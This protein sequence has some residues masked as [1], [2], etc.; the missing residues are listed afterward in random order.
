MGQGEKEGRPAVDGALGPDAAAVARD[1]ALG[2]READPVAGEFGR[3][4]QALERREQ[5]AGEGHVEA[6]AVVAHVAD[7]L[8]ALDL[9]AE[10]DARGRDLAGELPR[11]R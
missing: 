10:L 7:Q 3:A 6:R 9:R 5:V 8:V 2:G 4:M 11:V 1:D